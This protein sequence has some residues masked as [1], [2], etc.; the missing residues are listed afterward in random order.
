MK[1][2]TVF[3]M[4]MCVASVCFID[5]PAAQRRGIPIQVDRE[6]PARTWEEAAAI[7]Q[8]VAVVRLTGSRYITESSGNG[9]S[10]SP[11]TVYK[12]VVLEVVQNSGPLV[13]SPVIE[14]QRIGG[15]INTSDGPL[16]VDEAGFPPWFVGTKLLLF[17]SWDEKRAVFGTVGGPNAAFEVDREG[18]A[19][20]FGKGPLAAKHNR[21]PFAEVLSEVKE[22]IRIR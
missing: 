13:V 17:L 10:E 15:I 2:R 20:S 19:H 16:I 11:A 12:A 7:S 4:V 8:V 9:E 14:I 6:R 22:R 1:S 3:L 18:R 5:S 21:R